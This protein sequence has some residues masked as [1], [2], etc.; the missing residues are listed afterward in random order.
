MGA[1]PV[2]C[3]S[4]CWGLK[5]RAC[6]IGS[7]RIESVRSSR[8]GLGSASKQPSPDTHPSPVWPIHP[9]LTTSTPQS[10]PHLGALGMGPGKSTLVERFL[11]GKY[12]ASLPPNKV[13]GVRARAAYVLKG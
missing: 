12:T 3:A 5:V 8:V 10:I 2:R 9:L 1:T 7:N 13:A 11:S 6:V 4:S